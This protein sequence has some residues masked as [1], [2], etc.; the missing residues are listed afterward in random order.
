MHMLSKKD[1][2]SEELETLRRP[3]TPTTVGTAN[4][5]AQTNEEAQVFVHDLDPFV[6]VQLLEDTP[7]VLSLVPMSGP[8]VKSTPDQTREEYSLPVGKFVPLVVPGL[9]SNSGTSS[10]STTLPQDS[11]SSPSSPATER[12]DDAAPGNWRG[13][14]KTQHT[15]RKRDNNRASG[16]RC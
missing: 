15:N 4:G 9:S 2:R 6:T 10:S 16:D 3:R 12:S 1:L 14:P 7:A 13:S 11:S 8:A 5:E